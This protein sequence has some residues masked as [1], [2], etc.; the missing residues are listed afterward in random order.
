MR[1]SRDELYGVAIY[2]PVVGAPY[3]AGD[4]I[5]MTRAE[6]VKYLRWFRRHPGIKRTGATA[7]LKRYVLAVDRPTQEQTEMFDVFA[8]RDDGREVLIDG[9]VTAKAAKRQAASFDRHAAGTGCHA[10]CRLLG[11]VS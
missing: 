2:D 8:V 3:F 6:A 9:P 10:E 7:K 1:L 5:G 11:V 4:G